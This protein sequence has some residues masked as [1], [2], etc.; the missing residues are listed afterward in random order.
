MND[1]SNTHALAAALNNLEAGDEAL[2]AIARLQASDLLKIDAAILSA[3]DHTWKKAGFVTAGVLIAAPDEYE[4]LPEAFYAQRIRVLGDASR[5]EVKGD[6]DALKS[7]EIRFPTAK[8][9]K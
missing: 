4:D 2:Q 8:G 7:C 9:V 1:M 5:I 6:I 3:L